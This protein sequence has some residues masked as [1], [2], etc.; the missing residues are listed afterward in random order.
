MFSDSIFASYM[1]IYNGIR[2]YSE[3][4]AT[5]R[6]RTIQAMLNLHCIMY[7]FS[8]NDSTFQVPLDIYEELKKIV[9]EDYEKAMRNEPYY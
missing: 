1:V 6:K 5:Q 3:Y 8:K 9:I 4:C 2:D 7:S